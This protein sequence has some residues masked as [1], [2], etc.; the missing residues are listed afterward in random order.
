MRKQYFRAQCRNFLGKLEGAKLDYQ[1]VL[2]INPKN[3]LAKK[4]LAEIE[5]RLHQKVKWTFERPKSASKI[6]HKI[7]SIAEKNKP[8][9]LQQSNSENDQRAKSDS[10]VISKN[11]IEN[12]EGSE[13][14]KIKTENNITE[15]IPILIEEIEDKNKE[16]TDMKIE[17]E[18][19]KEGKHT[20]GNYPLLTSLNKE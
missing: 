18:S 11:V 14:E 15:N 19:T 5:A 3:K 12:I 17:P 4:E 10:T 8:E 13:Q 7:I 2:K 9:E 20:L 6:K 1:A 16:K